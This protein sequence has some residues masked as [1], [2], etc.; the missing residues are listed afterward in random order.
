MADVF[1]YPG[2]TDHADPI[3][4]DPTTPGP[5]PEPAAVA[6]ATVVGLTEGEGA[7]GGFLVPPVVV[8]HRWSKEVS[9]PWRGQPYQHVEAVIAERERKEERRRQRK[10]EL[11][12]RRQF[13]KK[14][15]QTKVEVQTEEE[16]EDLED[17]LALLD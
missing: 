2:A 10:R 5:S 1:L 12:F 11:E 7:R 15:E 3:L 8:G 17:I 16:V 6:A 14:V 13:R 9:D 4:R